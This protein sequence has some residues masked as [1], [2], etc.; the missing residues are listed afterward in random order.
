[1]VVNQETFPFVVIGNKSDLGEDA[2]AVSREQA[3]EVVRNLGADIEYIETSAKDNVNVSIAFE[4]LAEKALNRQME[5]QSKIDQNNSTTRALERE[6][7]R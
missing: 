4:K 5:M 7:L 3:E 2:R 6:K 1:M